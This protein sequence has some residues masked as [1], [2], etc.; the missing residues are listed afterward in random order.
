[1]RNKRKVII[2]VAPTGNVPTKDINPNTP[3]SPQEIVEDVLRCEKAGAAVAHIHARNKDAKPTN[4][5]KIYKE[6]L[7]GIKENS[8]VITMIST[9]ARG[10]EGKDRAN[11]ID[12]KPDMASLATGSSNFKSRVNANSPELIRYMAKKM[13]K[14]GGC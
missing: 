4:N 11:C 3:I 9:G 1:M 14:N 2:T 6:I 12:L 7:T 10:G 5:Q 13:Q 8:E